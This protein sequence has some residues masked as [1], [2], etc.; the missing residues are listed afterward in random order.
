[1]K[2]LFTILLL[3]VLAM[4]VSSC[5]H[6]YNTYNSGPYGYTRVYERTRSPAVYVLPPSAG[7]SR[8]NGGANYRY[9]SG[10]GM[11]W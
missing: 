10:C 6:G 7:Y 2:A 1:M 5:S 11:G 9:S 3:S 8:P 4:A